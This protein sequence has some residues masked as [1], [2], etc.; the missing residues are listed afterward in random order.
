MS[1]EV[2]RFERLKEEYESCSEFG[3]IYLALKDENHRVINGYP[4][5][6]CA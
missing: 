4:E 5:N 6:I 3:E 1:V 2:T